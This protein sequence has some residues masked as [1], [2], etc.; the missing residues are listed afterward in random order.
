MAAQTQAAA[1]G[2]GRAGRRQQRAI[3]RRLNALQIA[4]QREDAAH[5]SAASATE[6]AEF[7]QAEYEGEL[8]SV[9]P[10]AKR[11][12]SLPW[13]VV[14]AGVLAGLDVFPAW[15]AAEALGGD[16]FET[17]LVT[18]LLVAGLAGFAALLSYFDHDRR[19]TSLRFAFAAAV[20]LVLVESGLRFDYLVTVTDQGYRSAVIET[21]L[22]ALVTS[23]LLWM[24][25][26]V[27]LR[28]E[29]VALWRMRRQTKR[30]A[31]EAD[32]LRGEAGGATR[33]RRNEEAALELINNGAV[34]ELPNL[35]DR[36]KARLREIAGRRPASDS[37]VTPDEPPPVTPAAP[38]P[39]P[40]DVP[41]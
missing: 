21:G 18:G 32:A 11:R 29:S 25:Y 37:G 33:Q 5:A 12:G 34:T 7:A 14:A 3:R 39:P 24:S 13:A 28:A 10:D 2:D 19:R 4:E 41:R 40:D 35:V 1:F 9:D 8:Q 15:W 26:V 17:V 31:D 23:G 36:L 6:E 20:V 27:L 38:V 16:Y 22:L 30:L